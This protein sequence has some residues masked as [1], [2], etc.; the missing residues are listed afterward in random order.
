MSAGARLYTRLTTHTGTAALVGTRVYNTL[1]PQNAQYPC[2]VFQRI[3]GT[4]QRGTTSIRDARY[5]VSV[6]GETTASVQ[7]VAAQV[8]AA[9]E[10]WS[11]YGGGVFVR[12]ARIV[13][14]GDDYEPDERVYRTLIDVMLTID[15]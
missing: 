1:A 8:R 12:M 15:E 7:A 14:E 13:N 3:S 9:L 2:I 4:E 11:I 6:W 5:Q 10:E